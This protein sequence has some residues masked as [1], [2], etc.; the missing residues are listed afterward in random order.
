MFLTEV[1]FSSFETADPPSGVAGVLAPHGESTVENAPGVAVRHPDSFRASGR[2]LATI[3][4]RLLAV[5]AVVGVSLLL[6]VVAL[7]IAE[8]TYA[9][10]RVSRTD[11]YVQASASVGVDGRRLAAVGS[12]HHRVP[13]RQ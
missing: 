5:A 3:A 2:A 11:Q 13:R 1:G 12:S 7:V 9:P 6:H 8:Q 4:T 10:Y